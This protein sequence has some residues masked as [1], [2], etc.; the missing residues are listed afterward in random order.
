VHVY[1][2]AL[3]MMNRYLLEPLGLRHLAVEQA[4]VDW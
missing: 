2:P 1:T 4:G 3:T